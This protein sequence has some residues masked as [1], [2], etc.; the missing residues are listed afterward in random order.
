MPIRIKSGGTWLAPP[1]SGHLAVKDNTA[2]ALA[3]SSTTLRN[4]TGTGPGTTSTITVP[5]KGFL[6]ASC[7]S[8]DSSSGS[9]DITFTVSGGG[10]SWT[11]AKRQ[12]TQPGTAEIWVAYNL[13][14][15]SMTVTAT[16]A[17]PGNTSSTIAHELQVQV[18]VGAEAV[19]AGATGTSQ[20][21]SGLPN[22][23]ITTTKPNSWVVATNSDY[24]GVVA[25]TVGSGLTLDNSYAG[26][27]YAGSCFRTTGVVPFVGTVQTMNLTSPSAQRYNLAAIEIRSAGN[28]VTATKAAIK[29]GPAGSG[30]WIDSGYS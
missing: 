7:N 27:G 6:V 24:V 8:D 15:S 4:W 18:F 9:N 22:C 28:W 29:S 3:I 30:S 5:A 25:P 16:P 11:L 10:L 2:S 20:G 23:T 12:N 13:S 26:D 17:G 21:L 14:G 1:A 19:W